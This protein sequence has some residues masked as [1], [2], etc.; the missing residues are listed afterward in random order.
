VDP[1]HA[2]SWNELVEVFEDVTRRL[3]R[4]A[5]ES[6]GQASGSASADAATVSHGHG[7][8]GEAAF[9][10][11]AVQSRQDVLRILDLICDYYRRS[12]PSSPIP[13]LLTRARRLVDKDFMEIVNDL[14]PEALGSLKVIVGQPVSPPPAD[15]KQP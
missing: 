5:P 4:Y 7:Q 1:A 9:I 14:T 3:N 11:G 12:E 13:L 2:R 8:T 10:G 15:A 6:A